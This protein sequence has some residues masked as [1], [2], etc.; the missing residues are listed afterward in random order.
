VFGAPSKLAT[1]IEMSAGTTAEHPEWQVPQSASSESSGCWA[2]GLVSPLV[3]STQWSWWLFAAWRKTGLSARAGAVF[4]A[5]V[6]LNGISKQRINN[7]QKRM[8]VV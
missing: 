6:G 4:S 5:Q 3:A 2:T 1:V 7:Q 8:A